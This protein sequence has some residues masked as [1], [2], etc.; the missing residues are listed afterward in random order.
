M[1]VDF[2]LGETRFRGDS[3]A[4]LAKK[5]LAAILGAAA[6]TARLEGPSIDERRRG[7]FG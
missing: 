2:F 4:V 6:V 5:A 1:S 3:W 7:Q